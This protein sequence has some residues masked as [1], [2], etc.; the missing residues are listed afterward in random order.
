MNWLFPGFLLGATA[1]ALPVLLHLLRRRPRRTVSFPSLWFLKSAVQQNDRSQRI[2]RWIVLAL[3]CAALVLLAVAFGR[4]FRRVPGAGEQ[5]T[6]AVVI[7][8]SL[9]MQA[10]HRWET[11]RAWVHDKV[12]DVGSVDHIGLLALTP[13]PRWVAPLSTP[14]DLALKKLDALQP[15]WSTARAEP[16]LRMA[17]DALANV[18]ADNRVLVFMGDH[19]RLTWNGFD[20]GRPLATGVRPVFPPIPDAAKRQAALLPPTVEHTDFGFHARLQI[21][22]FGAADRRQLSTFRDDGLIAVQRQEVVL[23]ANATVTVDVDVRAGKAADLASFRFALDPDDLP[24]DDSVY[25]TW[26]SVGDNVVLLDAP[27]AGATA[28]YVA[29]ALAAAAEVKPALRVMLPPRTV[30]PAKAVAVLRNDASFSGDPAQRLEAF[31]RAGGSALVFIG[32]GPATPAWLARAAHVAVRPLTADPA[33]L[34]LRT[35]AMDHPLVTELAA[36]GVGPLLGWDFRKGWGLPLN[37]V[38]PIASW[39][40]DAAGIGEASLGAGRVLICGFAADRSD[41]DWL[42]REGAVPFLHRAVAH[43][44]GARTGGAAQPCFVGKPITLPGEGGVWRTLVGPERSQ[45]PTTVTSTVTP[46][47]PG[48]YEWTSGADRRLYAVNVPPEESDLAPWNEGAPWLRL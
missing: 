5:R 45:T 24:A 36:H 23:P 12:G 34:E 2:R 41:G 37:T 14:A 42:V 31:V 27:P 21:K 28:D 25:A 13:T 9:S 33:R 17:A 44:L 15:G 48:V 39:N 35:W 43:L 18:A 46:T 32:G 11:V 19:Q 10:G 29:T 30:W 26:Q 20:F 47:A 16:G 38:D 22:N 7:D 8:D 6:I 1:A 4:P 3:R 40:D